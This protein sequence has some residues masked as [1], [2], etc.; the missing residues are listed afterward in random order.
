[1][2]FPEDPT[3]SRLPTGGSAS[4][5]SAWPSCRKLLEV[6]DDVASLSVGGP[7]GL[8]R[9]SILVVDRQGKA[10]GA[11]RRGY[12]RIHGLHGERVISSA[13]DLDTIA[14]AVDLEVA[15]TLENGVVREIAIVAADA[16]VAASC[17]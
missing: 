13:A 15:A 17:S 7:N 14:R 5:L 4:L 11:R 1:M 9:D 8:E 10:I 6:Y 2:R 16:Q 3:S 12:A